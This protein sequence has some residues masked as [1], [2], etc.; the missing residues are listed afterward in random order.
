MSGFAMPVALAYAGIGFAPAD[1]YPYLH[2]VFVFVAFTATVPIVLLYTI[3]FFKNSIF[4]RYICYTYVFFLIIT[5]AFMLN[6]YFGVDSLI[7]NVVAQKVVIYTEMICMAIV[8][9][10]VSKVVEKILEKKD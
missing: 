8:G 6:M 3:L 7:F 5:F 10:G 9:F 2:G 4:P 1:I